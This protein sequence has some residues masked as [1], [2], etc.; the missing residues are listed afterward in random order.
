MESFEQF[1]QGYVGK[2]KTTNGTMGKVTK[3]SLIE[4]S[5]A[6]GLKEEVELEYLKKFL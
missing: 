4:E 1:S 6:D 3:K 5:A 2:D